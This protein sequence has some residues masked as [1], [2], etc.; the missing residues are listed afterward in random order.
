L[1][2]KHATLLASAA[3]GL[4]GVLTELN[5]M[6]WTAFLHRMWGMCLL[7]PYLER[8]ETKASLSTANLEARMA[9]DL[10]DVVLC[11]TEETPPLT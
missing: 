3:K 2:A 11:R 10:D 5:L 9:L 6:N 8:Q 4:V 1:I 7:H